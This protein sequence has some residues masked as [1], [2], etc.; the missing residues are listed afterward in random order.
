MSM[1]V[2]LTS[3]DDSACTVM[4]RPGATYA[5]MNT[6]CVGKR[7]QNQIYFNPIRIPKSQ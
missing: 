1:T 2:R 4:L 6:E 5:V 7:S 3:L